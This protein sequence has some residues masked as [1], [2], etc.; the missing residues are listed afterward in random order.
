MAIYAY[1]AK[2]GPTEVVQ[3]ELEAASQQRAVIMLSDMG[4]VPISVVE[5]QSSVAKDERNVSSPRRHESGQEP[6]MNPRPS[7]SL[8]ASLR[9]DDNRQ[10]IEENRQKRKA[11]AGKSTLKNRDIDI[12]TRELASLTRAGVPVLESLS[13]I[14]QQAESKALANVAGDLTARVKNGSMLS[15]ALMA[16]PVFNNM[17]LNLV[18]SG[19]KGGVL[20]AVLTRLVDYREKEQE[21]RQ[22]IQAALAYPTLMI[23]VAIA[24]IFIMFTYFIPKLMGLFEN[25][26]QA[27][28]LPT[29]ILMGISKFMSGNWFWILLAVFLLAAAFVKVNRGGKSKLALDGMKLRLFFIGRFI[30]NAEI[31]RFSKTM[32]LLFENGIPLYESVELATEAMGNDVLKEGLRR[33]GGDVLN[34]GCTLSEALSKI[35]MF[36]KFAISIIAVGEKSGKMSESLDE[37]ASAYEKEVEQAIKIMMTLLEPLLILAVGA[38]VGFIVFAMLLPIFNIGIMGS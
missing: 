12:F 9:G 6:G 31:A 22:K 2:K 8:R 37:I 32:G 20:E 1:K 34:Q 25:M 19:E 30:K 36:P 38:I 23:A 10:T 26:K 17:Y 27:L 18:R 3:G 21:L 28:P 14:S 15:E 13:L 35:N 33:A 5:K 4:L 7:I 29:K 16:Y 11:P 24:T